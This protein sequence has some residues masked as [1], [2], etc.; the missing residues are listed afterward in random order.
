M[1]YR[2]RPDKDF[3]SEFRNAA[4][5]EL[6]E[7][8]DLLEQT[9]KGIHEAI[10]DA[11]KNI[12]RLR[13]LY[14]LVAKAEPEFRKRENA[15]LRDSAR[16]LSTV[17]DAEAL[18]ENCRYLCENARSEEERS[19][20]QR[21]TDIMIARRNWLEETER[22]LPERMKAVVGALFEAIDALAEVSFDR[23]RRHNARMLEKAWRRTG[24][25]LSKTLAECHGD[26]SEET[27]HELRKRMQD[28][29]HYHSLLRD[30]WPSAMRARRTTAKELAEIL[31]HI[32]DFSVL[33]ALVNSEPQLFTRNDDL[34]F[35]L[36]ALIFHEQRARK[37][38]LAVA[39]EFLAE[40]PDR[41]AA[42]IGLLWL[43]AAN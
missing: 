2:I 36:D 33:S 41:E 23:G 12:K 14:R 21:V 35:L 4:E 40:D 31:G 29:R 24:R 18:V 16:S 1:A 37:E 28:Y 15:R 26:A 17:R 32:H 8:I 27:F 20:L 19:A 42:R 43:D 22:E 25:A 3:T 7:A 39:E 5:G 30:I 10:H 34:A 38:A 11:R 6:R 9:P 13:A